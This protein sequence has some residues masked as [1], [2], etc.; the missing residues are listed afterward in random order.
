VWEQLKKLVKDCL[1]ENNGSSYC[2]FRV[3]GAALSAAGIPTFLGCAVYAAYQGH[4]DPIAF[5]G[6]FAAMMS[7]LGVLAGGI[8][9]KAKTDT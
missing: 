3:A 1:T 2:P 9:L 6:G 7:G 4:F 8:A 5:G